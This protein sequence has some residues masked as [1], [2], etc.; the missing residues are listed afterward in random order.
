MARFRMGL[1]YEQTSENNQPL[2]PVAPAIEAGIDK[3][4]DDCPAMRR[5]G[6]QSVAGQRVSLCVVTNTN[7]RRLAAAP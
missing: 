2:R 4:A 1:D 5:G 3:E 7:G 6:D